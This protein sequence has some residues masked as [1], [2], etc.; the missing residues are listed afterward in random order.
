MIDKLHIVSAYLADRSES[1][2]EYSLL[3]RTVQIAKRISG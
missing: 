1:G 2:I 3:L